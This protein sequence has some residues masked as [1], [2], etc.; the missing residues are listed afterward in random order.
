MV[1]RQKWVRYGSLLFW[2]GAQALPA[3]VVG[4]IDAGGT[5]DISAELGNFSSTAMQALIT[6]TDDLEIAG[7]L[8]AGP[9]GY[10]FGTGS[11]MSMMRRS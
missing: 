8:D 5:V 4:V 7:V 10:D 3:D 1:K 9:A 11:S 2:L 6:A